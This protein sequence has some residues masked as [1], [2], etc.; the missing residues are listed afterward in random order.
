MK[1]ATLT[2][3]HW[4]GELPLIGH[5]VKAERGRT[6][7]R[8]IEIKRAKPGLRYVAKFIC[9][10]ENPKYLPHDAVVHGWLWSKR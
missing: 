4:D 7:Y 6:A 8:I 1:P 5:F 10:R 9:E 2:V 3:L